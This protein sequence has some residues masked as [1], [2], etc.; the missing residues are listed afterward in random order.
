MEPTVEWL[1]RYVHETPT[2]DQKT[3]RQAYRKLSLLEQL[4]KRDEITAEQLRAADKLEKHYFGSLGHDVRSDDG[5]TPDPLEYPQAYHA[6]K[7]RRAA[8]AVA[9]PRL[10]GALMVAIMNDSPRTV[11]RI[12]FTARATK[13]REIARA[14]GLEIINTGL[15]LLTLHWGFLTHEKLAK[16]PNAA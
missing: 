11:E 8:A 2:L 10:W 7:L 15:E 1:A 12:G 9:S 14:T 5:Y 13:R 3:N 6:D 16:P 4:R